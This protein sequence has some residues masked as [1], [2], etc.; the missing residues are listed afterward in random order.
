MGKSEAARVRDAL[1]A[2]GIPARRPAV[3]VENASRNAAVFGG[4]VGSLAAL[5]DRA[6]DGPALLI[7]GEAL[8]RAA[9]EHALPADGD[10]AQRA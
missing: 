9:A 8:A 3:L 1:V 6:G 4:S 2:R 10:E 5:A 7:I